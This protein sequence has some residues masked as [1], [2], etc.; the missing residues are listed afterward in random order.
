MFER[1]DDV[2]SKPNGTEEARTAQ[3][4]LEVGES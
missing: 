1:L 2:L 3:K 4:G